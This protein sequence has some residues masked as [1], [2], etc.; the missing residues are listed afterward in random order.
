MPLK[1]TTRDEVGVHSRKRPRLDI[2]APAKLAQVEQLT[3]L[4]LEAALDTIRSSPTD[5]GTV[6]LLV[7]RTAVGERDTP[8]EIELDTELGVVGDNWSTRPN[9]RT[10]DGGPD[11]NGQV[12][13]VNAR[14]LAV[15]AGVIWPILIPVCVM[16]VGTRQLGL[17]ILMHEAAHGGLSKDAR[18]NDFLGHWLC[19]VPVGASSEV[20][21]SV[22]MPWRWSRSRYE[23]PASSAPTAPT[24]TTSAPARRAAIAWLPPLPPAKRPAAS[25]RTVSPGRG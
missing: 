25:P 21:T 16:I 14:A 13:L 20:G 1:P 15:V 17:A 22:W 11:P 4:E 24:M 10:P 5:L 23:A 2:G 8:L 19:A 7:R 3:D 12:T 18:L 6:E 9:R